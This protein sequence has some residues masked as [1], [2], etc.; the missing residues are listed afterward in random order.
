MLTWISAVIGSLDAA[1][2]QAV[3]IFL[4]L[5]VAVVAAVVGFSQVREA[6]RSREEQ[7]R[8]YVAAYLDVGNDSSSMMMFLVVKNFGLTAARDVTIA[9]DKPIPRSWLS[10]GKREQIELF[11]KLPVMVPGQE[12]RTLFDFGPSRLTAGLDEAYTLTV[13]SKTSQGRPLPSEDFVIDWTTNAMRIDAPAKT[14]HHVAESLEK[15]A[16]EVGRWTEG[17]SGISVYARD[18]D[19]K[20]AD[21]IA[22]LKRRGKLPPDWDEDE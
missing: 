19:R 8:P 12:W 7:T 16:T 21:Q 4:T 9:S 2:W 14:T 6:R 10:G 3:G 15:I 1:E 20:D 17:L 22:D 11:E 18:G 13:A 5:A